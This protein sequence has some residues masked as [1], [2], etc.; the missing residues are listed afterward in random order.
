MGGGGFMVDPASP[1]DDFL[2]S[3]STAARP[4]ICFVPTPSGDG[5]RGF[6]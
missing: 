5:D 6:P 1:L 4:R 3:L 2:L